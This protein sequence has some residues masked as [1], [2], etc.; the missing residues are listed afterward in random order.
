MDRWEEKLQEEW[1]EH[2]RSVGL[3]ALER[4]MT[5]AEVE[6]LVRVLEESGLARPRLRVVK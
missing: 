1:E 2:L 6:H 4:P 3:E 5:D